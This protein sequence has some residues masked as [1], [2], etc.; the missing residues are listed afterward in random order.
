MP[1]FENVTIY[2]YH[3]NDVLVTREKVLLESLKHDVDIICLVSL[4]AV[5]RNE[6]IMCFEFY[7]TIK[8]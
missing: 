8:V 6:P 7:T 4:L 3:F 5:V 2:H 1:A